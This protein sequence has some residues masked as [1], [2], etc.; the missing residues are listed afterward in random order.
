MSVREQIY[1]RTTAPV[2]NIA[3]SVAE[4]VG[5]ERVHRDN[6]SWL[7]VDTGRLVPGAVGKFGGP[8]LPHADESAFRPEEELEAPDS[9]N[10]EIR[11]WQSHGP[12]R[13]T[14]SGQDIEAAAASRLF[15]LVSALLCAPMI[16]VRHDDELVSAAMPGRGTIGYPVG[17]SIYEWDQGKWDGYVVIDHATRPVTD[18]DST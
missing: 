13:D 6:H 4:L 16:H 7:V 2:R 8:V 5:G 12:R 17:T 18:R 14:I 3:G 1:V 9:Y 15:I 10:V 11:L